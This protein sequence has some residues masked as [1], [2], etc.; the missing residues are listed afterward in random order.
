[1]QDILTERKLAYYI[2]FQIYLRCCI[3]SWNGR[4]CEY[5]L[6]YQEEKPKSTSFLDRWFGLREP[7]P[8]QLSRP[9]YLDKVFDSSNFNRGEVVGY[10]PFRVMEI[11][12][13]RHHKNKKPWIIYG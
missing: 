3:T 8:R 9:Q 12:N 2:L 13:K 6:D 1:M 4:C 10:G 5:P 7:R 11:S